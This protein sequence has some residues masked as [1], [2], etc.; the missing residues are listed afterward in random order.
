[1]ST[2]TPERVERLK[3]LWN[4]G[5]SGAAIGRQLGMSKNAVV[6]K[7]G[8]LNLATRSNPIRPGKGAPLNPPVA[9]RK[10]FLTGRAADRTK[11]RDKRLVAGMFK[12]GGLRFRQC[13]WIAGE[14]RR[15][16][17][18]KCLAPTVNGSPWCAEHIR[19]IWV[20]GKPRDRVSE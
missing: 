2:W 10:R 14:P 6:G 17:S 11:G 9:V 1:M 7:A 19:R 3:E 4:A 12:H 16:D 15:D 18:C 5:L 8:R 20:P 13:Q